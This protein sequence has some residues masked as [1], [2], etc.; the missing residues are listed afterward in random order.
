M[1]PLID[2]HQAFM[3]AIDACDEDA[4]AEAMRRHLTEILGALPR[5]EAEHP[6]LFS[7]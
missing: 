2:Q 7:G 4:A 1:L 5:V 3:A 6:E